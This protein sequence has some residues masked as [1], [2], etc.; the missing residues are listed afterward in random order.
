[1]S[2]KPVRIFLVIPPVLYARQ[3]LI[4]V[5]HISSYL[6]Q[7]GHA[8]KSWDLNLE[9][10]VSNDC[11]SHFWK[12][13]ENCENYFR[14]NKSLFENWIERILDFQP[15]I[16]GFSVWETTEYFS[17][18]MAEMIKKKNKDIV[19]V[20][21]GPTCVYFGR[22][23]IENPYVDI[24]VSG[25]GEEVLAEVAEAYRERGSVDF[26]SGCLIRK[27]D[28]IIDCGSRQDIRDL[29]SLPYPDFSDFPLN[30]YLFKNHLPISFSRGCAW[31]CTYCSTR[32]RWARLRI[33][34]A[35][36]IYKEIVQALKEY[37]DLK[38]FEV[39]DPAVNQDLNLVSELCDLIIAND[40]KVEFAG[41]AQIRPGM[42]SG[43]LKKMRNAG[44]VSLNYGI[45][46]GSQNVLTSMGR[47]YA[48]SEAERVIK[49]TYNAGIGVTLNFIIGYPN[50]RE[51]D[52]NQ[53]LKFV[54]RVGNYV[55]NIAEPDVCGITQSDLL[56]NPEKYNI[57]FPDNNYDKWMT[58]D[59][60]NT[61]DIRKQRQVV[62]ND[63]VKKIN[64]ACQSLSEDRILY[65]KKNAPTV[66]R[67]EK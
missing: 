55:T 18:K 66:L 31:H 19:I 59:G 33:R 50:E 49:D 3:P 57:V 40:I 27:N 52:F 15:Q 65:S 42:D 2:S 43:Y 45:E 30:K 25:E 12:Q 28:Q 26:L 20:C 38:R 5:A 17:L 58:I 9:Q 44:F 61:P 23:V 48:V 37:A 62:F 21:G 14:D 8:V 16:V 39:C 7:K 1:M 10:L 36:M 4:G 41:F 47:P 60:S 29:D 35:G 53:T 22:K 46:S 13:R 6:K 54:E 24:V 11:D 34:K 32:F 67:H 63:F 51:E 56:F 64:V